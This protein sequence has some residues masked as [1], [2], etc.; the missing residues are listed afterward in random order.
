[1]KAISLVFILLLT[2]NI[3]SQKK[4]TWKGEECM[5]YPAEVHPIY[6][7]SYYYPSLGDRFGS[8][9]F[10]KVNNRKDRKLMYYYP[11]D[12]DLFPY[13]GELRDGKYIAYLKGKK[14]KVGCQFEIA[15]GM[16]NGNIEVYDFKGK[17]IQKGQYKDNLK[18]GEWIS[19]TPEGQICE[20][21]HF[22]A[23]LTDGEQIMYFWNAGQ[24]REKEVF[25]D[26]EF[27]YG[28]IYDLGG[29]L[30]LEVSQD[31][32]DKSYEKKLIKSG[33]LAEH[34]EID[35]SDRVNGAIIPEKGNEIKLSGNLYNYY[36][37][38]I[39]MYSL[40]IA[41]SNEGF[42]LFK[43]QLEYLE[44]WADYSSVYGHFAFEYNMGDSAFCYG[45][46]EKGYYYRGGNVK[47]RFDSLTY[48]GHTYTMPEK[49]LEDG[50]V[51]LSYD[52]NY[53]SKYSKVSGERIVWNG[54]LVYSTTITNYKKTT[55][56]EVWKDEKYALANNSGL[57]SVI[58]RE[59]I[60][61]EQIKLQ[62]Y[63]VL[64]DSSSFTRNYS[65]FDNGNLKSVTDKENYNKKMK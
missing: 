25:S 40:Y 12:V 37:D 27:T 9:Y 45:R 39:P 41:T 24:I 30:A 44:N 28:A 38:T 13:F 53:E 4:V 20:V 55:E 11:E 47:I 57:D 35:S 22:K 2:T 19:Y 14:N 29:S 15:N 10:Q 51:Q 7:S 18:E 54:N 52:Y 46:V 64:A 48:D 1:M 21:N 43:E 60:R 58:L 50:T 33:I 32:Q 34:I 8:R 3:Y 26:N 23:G 49:M 42:S 17:L 56:K 16:F 65:Y 63:F 5:V 31:L 6:R 36:L 61:N 59:E 62:E